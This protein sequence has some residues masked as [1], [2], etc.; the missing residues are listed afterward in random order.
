MIR[1]HLVLAGAVLVTAFIGLFVG[2]ADI[3]I[4]QVWASLLGAV[5]IGESHGVAGDVVTRIR[6]PR[7]VGGL[8]VGV[9]LGLA[10]AAFQGVFQNSVAEPYLLGVPAGSGL[11]VVVVSALSLGA[12]Q[13]PVTMGAAIVFAVMVALLIQ[14]IG[15]TRA[16]GDGLI[17]LGVAIGFSLLAL[18]M[19]AIFSI[20]SPRLPTFAYFVFGSLGVVTWPMAGLAALVVL[21][22]AV[23]LAR[24][25]R[26]LDLMSLGP[27]HARSLGVDVGAVSTLVMVAVGVVVGSAVAIAGVIGFVGIIAPNLARKTVGLHHRHLMVASALFGSL[28]LLWSDI[29]IRGVAGRVEVPIGIVTAAVGGPVLALM[30]WRKRWM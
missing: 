20:D 6:A 10:G 21:F 24:V 13:L 28:F 7:V 16:A 26:H 29:L 23:L 1:R 5:G 30:L 22:G 19:L 4:A 8:V 17:L 3:S 2:A 11:G 27:A 12:W 9:G 25:G 15:S 14:R 18:T